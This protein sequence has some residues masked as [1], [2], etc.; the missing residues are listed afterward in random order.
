MHHAYFTT[1]GVEALWSH[2]A[3]YSATIPQGLL[4]LP[5]CG[6]SH[7]W[8]ATFTIEIV[9]GDKGSVEFDLQHQDAVVLGAQ[10]QGNECW[11]IFRV[12]WLV[13]SM[14]KAQKS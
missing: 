1:L 7:L 9:R 4:R 12:S 14:N 3:R 13:F 11:G 10:W 8:Y 6:G 2:N 5:L